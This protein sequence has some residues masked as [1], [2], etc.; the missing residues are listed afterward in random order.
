M[1]RFDEFTAHVESGEALSADDVRELA[2][3]PDI[4]RVGMLADALKR[5]LHGQRVT[6]LRV[7]HDT[8]EPAAGELR[9]TGAPATLTDALQAVS[10]ARA[11]AGPRTLAAW[12]WADIERLGGTDIVGALE[13]LRGTGLDAVARLPL[14]VTADPAAA[15]DALA[16][17]GFQQARLT[18]EKAPGS[19]RIDLLIAAADLRRRFPIVKSINPLPLALTAFRPTTGYDDVRMVA[20][21]RL[22]APG[23]KRVQ[24]DWARYGPKLAQVALSFGADDID[25]VSASDAAPEGRRRAPLE[26]I[27][28]NIEAAGFEPVERDGI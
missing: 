26:E 11:A 6:F 1:T 3:S 16:T 9:L 8:L 4:L 7:S 24:I 18:I 5:R 23:I 14:D 12:T 21:A 13:Q 25:S 10:T 28:R 15:L 20:L 19:A 22:A 17:A 2:A 27:R